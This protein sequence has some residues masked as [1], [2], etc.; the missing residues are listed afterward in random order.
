MLIGLTEDLLLLILELRTVSAEE[1]PRKCAVDRH[2]ELWE[3]ISK[4]TAYRSK[5]SIDILTL[6]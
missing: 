4:A 6:R 1:G 2:D 3:Q 5:S